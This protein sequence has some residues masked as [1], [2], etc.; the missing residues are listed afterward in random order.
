MATVIESPGVIR[1]DECYTK[2]EFWSRVGMGQ[3]AWRAAIRNG[4]PCI[5]TAGRVYVRGQDWIAYLDRVAR[6][7]EAE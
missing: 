1:P 2:E 3:T 4:L 7:A 6:E 5:R